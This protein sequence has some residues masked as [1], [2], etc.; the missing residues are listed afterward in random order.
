MKILR[1]PVFALK[2]EWRCGTSPHLIGTRGSPTE[3]LAR[4]GRV[5]T[6]ALILA[7][8]LIS[9]SISQAILFFSTADPAHNT[10]APTGDLAN[11]GWDLQGFWG[12]YLGTPIAPEY[13][14]TAKHVGGVVG[15]SFTFKG[16]SYT[17][18]AFFDDPESDLRI[19]RVQGR[20]PA[21][22]P[23]YTSRDEVGSPLV[24][25]GRGTLRGEEVKTGGLLGS[26]LRGWRWGPGDG[27][28]RWGQNRVG[29]IFGSAF[30]EML[31]VPFD[32][33]GVP[34]E[35]H[36]SLG[37]S[38]GSVFIKDGAIWKLAGI[39]YSVDG[40][41]N[42]SP[43]GDG[44]QAAIFDDTGLYRKSNGIW[45]QV[46]PL[47]GQP[48]AFYATRISSRLDWINQNIITAAGDNPISLQS[49]TAINGA[50]VTETSAQINE[51][52]RS[53]TLPAP[54]TERFYRISAPSQRR[55]L[56]IRTEAG[57]LLLEY[58]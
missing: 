25:F 6:T 4:G 3:G 21:Y 30:G 40:P 58:E 45:T 19:C 34:N 24:V 35:A 2:A 56:S 23:L 54:G 26:N 44:F 57:W 8:W 22:A 17:T 55:I 38:G 37:D 15:D 50:Y 28:Q 27:R 43:S 47:S 33:N 20:F 7:L 16:V 52:T 12:S 13:F 41:Y 32:S 36:L 48:G 51:G 5:N 31:R 42:T 1:G 46:S 29:S 53:I 11:S 10:T 18:I 14:I 49:A 39:N 9:S